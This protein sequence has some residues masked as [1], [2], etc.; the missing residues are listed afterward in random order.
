MFDSLCGKL[1]R[2]SEHNLESFLDLD[3]VRKNIDSI[4]IIKIMYL[5]MIFC[6]AKYE[7]HRVNS[8]A[9]FF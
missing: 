3:K 5:L 4:I 1:R 9:V 8:K 2:L 7:L 6:L